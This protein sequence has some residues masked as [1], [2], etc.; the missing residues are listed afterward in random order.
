MFNYKL[1]EDTRTLTG[2]YVLPD[3][4]ELTASVKWDSEKEM[5]QNLSRALNSLE[6]LLEEKSELV[7]AGNANAVAP[8][9][10]KTTAK[11]L[12]IFGQTFY[13]ATM[14]GHEWDEAA[15]ILFGTKFTAPIVDGKVKV[16]KT[17][18]THDPSFIFGLGG[19][20]KAVALSHKKSDK[21]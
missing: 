15:F 8:V 6:T 13:L 7:A 14:S 21:G 2:V 11:R 17:K 20:T 10:A 3:G 4:K 5:D 9:G 19:A 12:Q 1:D 18:I 16:F